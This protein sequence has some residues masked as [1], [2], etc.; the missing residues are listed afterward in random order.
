MRIATA[1]IFDNQTAAM[2]NLTVQQQQLGLDLSTGKSLNEPSDDPT[3]IGQDLTIRST[4]ASETTTGTNLASATDQL[5]ATDGSLSTLTNILQSA[6]QLA[7][8]GATDTLSTSQRQAIGSQVDQLLNEA[9]G[10]ANTSYGGRYIFAGTSTLTSAPVQAQGSPT[11]S[12]AFTG[13]FQSQGQ[14]FLNGQEFSLSTSLQEA[15]NYR[16]ADGSPDVFQVLMNLRN[17]LN[18][19]TVVDQSATSVNQVGTLISASTSLQNALFASPLTPDASGDYSIAINGTPPLGSPANVLVTFLPTDTMAQVVQKINADT[20]QTGVSAA[21][22]V[23]TQK[24][25][26][27]TANQATFTVTD[28]A[29]PGSSS[30]GNFVEAMGLSTNA[31]FVQNLSTQLGDIDKVLN[32]TL[33]ARAVIGGRID[34]LNQITDQN[35]TS[36]TNNTATQSGIEDANIASTVTQFTA[37]QTALQAA[38]STTTKLESKILFDYVQ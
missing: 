32:T 13:N 6:R 5:T 30:T 35:N 14:V 20:T 4:I 36:I 11:S 23:K 10:I 33:S 25:I 18:N 21:F 8:E 29:S 12:V 28:A 24:L 1:T 22:D 19:G 9:I 27:S 38:Y 34:A 26:L 16:A 3:Q 2:D 17:T 7:I 15:F 37:T 31:D